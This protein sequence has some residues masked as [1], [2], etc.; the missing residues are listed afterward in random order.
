MTSKFSTDGPICPYCN[1]KHRPEEPIYYD[2]DV[3]ELECGQ[4]DRTFAVTIYTSTSWTTEAKGKN[5][6]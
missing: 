3:T 5:I 6:D 2:E 1:H 4:C